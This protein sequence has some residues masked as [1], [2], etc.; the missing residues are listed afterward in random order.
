VALASE[1]ALVVIRFAD[2][3]IARD[4]SHA[5]DDDQPRF[6]Q[7]HAAMTVDQ[8]TLVTVWLRVKWECFNS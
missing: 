2:D 1:G 5:L 3:T 7:S 8:I 4:S 6:F